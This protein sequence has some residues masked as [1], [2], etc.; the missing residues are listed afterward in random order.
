M[1]RSKSTILITFLSSWTSILPSMMLD[2]QFLLSNYKLSE[3]T[4]K[5]FK[6]Q[7]NKINQTK[8]IV[9]QKERS[10][11]RRSYGIQKW[12]LV[13]TLLVYFCCIILLN[14][15]R[16]E[17]YLTSLGSPGQVLSR[18]GSF[19][20]SEKF[21]KVW[22]EF[23]LFLFFSF[24]NKTSLSSSLMDFFPTTLFVVND[25]AVFFLTNWTPNSFSL[26]GFFRCIPWLFSMSCSSFNV[27]F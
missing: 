1:S 15:I 2:D 3:S 23:F 26:I 6:N 27:N 7:L 25:W 9:I 21:A 4:T 10:H 17:D 22:H 20:F 16:L 8:I 14:F 12:K 5:L 13:L 24:L 19:L 11:L 18:E